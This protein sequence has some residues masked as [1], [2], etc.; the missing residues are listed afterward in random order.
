MV[1]DV[2]NMPVSLDYQLE[3][4]NEYSIQ[5]EDYTKLEIPQS[6]HSEKGDQIT[7]MVD[8]YS[9]RENLTMPKMIFIGTIDEYWPVDAIKNYIDSIPGENYIQY[10]PNAGHD[11]GDKVQAFQAL[12]S[13]LSFTLQN[14][15]YPICKWD[16]EENNDGI[17][18]KAKAS[19]EVLVDALVWS[20]E[21]ADRDFRDDTWTS[22]SLKI[23]NV[24][25]ISA[26]IDFPGNG[27][28]AFY[29]DLKYVDLHGDE[30]VE[31][32]RM[33]VANNTEVL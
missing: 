11:L 5:I 21:S 6:V 14:Q 20:A 18:L 2:L 25:D 1:I 26:T 28:K 23:S 33:F 24:E 7:Q 8:P 27:Y 12:S 29:L 22:T 30:F 32:T 13:F 17:V 16:L 31:S 15:S 4:W 9:Y 3:A 19:Q 10:V